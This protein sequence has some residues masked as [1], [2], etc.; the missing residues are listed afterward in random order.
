MAVEI[1]NK[2]RRFLIKRNKEKHNMKNIHD[3]NVM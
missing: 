3:T 1:N 2:V